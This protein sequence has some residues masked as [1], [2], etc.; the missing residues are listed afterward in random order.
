MRSR[1]NLKDFRHRMIRKGKIN[2][3]LRYGLSIEIDLKGIDPEKAT[4]GAE[5]DMRIDASGQDIELSRRSFSAEDILPQ[6]S[7]EEFHARECKE[8]VILKIPPGRHLKKPIIIESKI[9]SMNSNLHL[10]L[11]VGEDS[12][13][14]I[15]DKVLT[16]SNISQKARQKNTEGLSTHIVSITSRVGSKTRYF[17]IQDVDRQRLLYT[18]KSAHM[19]R[20]S[21]IDLYSFDIGSMITLSDTVSV[22]EDGYAKS[23]LQNLFFA[24]DGQMFDIAGQAIHSSG[25]TSSLVEAKGV[26]KDDSKGL[27][28]GNIH[29]GPDADQSQGFQKSKLLMMGKNPE[30]DAIPQLLIDNENV[31]CSHAVGIGRI[32]DEHMFYLMSRGLSRKTSE[33]LVIK[34]FFENLIDNI[35]DR[36]SR[37]ELRHKIELKVHS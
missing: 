3:K 33:E 18:K 4:D 30:A 19:Q 25:G 32:D 1:Q 5:T 9:R 24:D 29:I 12:S 7:F 2:T 27:Y 28:R 37:D 22:M 26:I 11:D 14:M 16:G 21:S 6:N 15:V 31:R 8:V 13:V 10:V 35:P 36:H 23:N 34:G 20:E 17:H